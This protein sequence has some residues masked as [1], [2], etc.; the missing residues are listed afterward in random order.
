M[1][2]GGS[3]YYVGGKSTKGSV[4][5]SAITTQWSQMSF[6][7]DVSATQ[8]SWN[9]AS[10]HRSALAATSRTGQEPEPEMTEAWLCRASQGESSK[11]RPA[12]LSE[13]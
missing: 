1:G 10:D 7:W 6:L 5:S 12:G 3:E 13:V 2:F 11:K 4:I 8:R 9:T